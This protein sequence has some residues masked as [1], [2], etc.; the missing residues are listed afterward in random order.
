MKKG[1]PEASPS[2]LVQ[3]IKK[4]REGLEDYGTKLP[5]SEQKKL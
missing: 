5:D 4:A 3:K 2:T 1:I